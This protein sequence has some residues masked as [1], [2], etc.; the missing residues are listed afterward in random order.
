MAIRFLLRRVWHGLLL[1]FGVSVLS[2]ALFELAPGD[3]LDEMRVNPQISRQTSE[4]FRERYGLDKPLV[5]RYAHWVRSTARGDLGISFA[6]NMPVSAI[7]WRRVGNTFLLGALALLTTWAVAVP[8]G[9]W[10]AARARGWIDRPAGAAASILVALPDLLVGLACLLFA[11]RTGL[12]RVNGS[13]ALAVV[14]LA[15]VSFPAVFRHTRSGVAQVLREP[16]IDHLCANGIPER[17]IL[18]GH[19]L[20]AAL[21]PLIGLFG[22]S[23]A[24]MLSS[25]FIVEVILGWP[26]LG[27]LLLEAILARD[28][29]VVIAAV[30]LSTLL[31][32]TGNLV[33]D[34]L[35]YAADP[36]IR[37]EES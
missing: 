19:A 27:P 1:L 10:A 12:F 36:R 16:F 15:L 37:T 3:Y 8:L 20:P 6:Y 17:R 13:L 2:F 26:G 30:M 11:V 22:L 25:S 18:F 4:A 21:N 23:L 29:H 7:L 33:A 24:S 5:F 9:V 34:I 31:L 28:V 35:L 14:A 32:L